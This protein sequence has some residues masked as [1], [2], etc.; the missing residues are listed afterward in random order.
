MRLT[1]RT[2]L[3]YMDEILEPADHEDIGRK[4]EESEFATNLMHRIRDVSC[5]MRLGAPKVSGRGMGLDPNTVAE[6]LDNTLAG[7]RVPDFEKICLESDVHL[8]EVASCHQILTLVLGEAA[9]V[10]SEL[11]NRMYAIGARADETTEDAGQRVEA[12]ARAAAAFAA[13]ESAAPPPLP[14]PASRARPEVPDYL[15]QGS[16]SRWKPIAIT[17]VLAVCLIIAIVLAAGDPLLNMLGLGKNET[18]QNTKPTPPVAATPNAGAADKNNDKKTDANANGGKAG[19]AV[20]KNGDTKTGAGDKTG[21]ATAGAGTVAPTNGDDKTGPTIRTS[22]P[23]S[24][25]P[26]APAPPVVDPNTGAPRVVGPTVPGPNPNIGPP[27]HPPTPDQAIPPAPA[28]AGPA[29]IPP[30]VVPGGGPPAEFLDQR[31]GRLLSPQEVLLQLDGGKGEWHRAAPSAHVQRRRPN[32]HA[33]HVPPGDHP[34][35]WRLV[36]AESGNAG[37]IS[38]HRSGDSRDS[39]A[40]RSAGHSHGGQA[41]RE[42]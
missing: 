27:P 14:T 22:V 25:P 10:T 8:A 35:V 16:R 33:P 36:G 38:G 42:T 39:A 40:L 15:R 9:D 12:G 2:M 20:G 5:R 6:Y 11:R 37:R 41:R 1:L 3:A 7:E 28:S 13:E 26:I 21:D 19:D 34:F 24:P 23:V 18:A 32:P 4:I 29:P 30:A 31:V 17:A